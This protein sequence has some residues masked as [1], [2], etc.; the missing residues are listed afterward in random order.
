MLLALFLLWKRLQKNSKHT[1]SVPTNSKKLVWWNSGLLWKKSLSMR[2][3]E[4]NSTRSYGYNSRSYLHMTKFQ[5]SCRPPDQLIL[6]IIFQKLR[7]SLCIVNHCKNNF[8]YKRIN[9][10]CPYQ[11]H[12]LLHNQ[13]LMIQLWLAELFLWMV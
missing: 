4:W 7:Q 13:I 1:D 10:L 11:S 9:Y 2:R 12:F 8:V 3:K 5:E 6:L